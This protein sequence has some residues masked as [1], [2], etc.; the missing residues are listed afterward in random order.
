MIGSSFPAVRSATAR[1]VERAMLL[2]IAHGDYSPGERVPTCEQFARE[3]GVNKNTVSK[4][5][6]ALADLGYL[7]TVPGRGTFIVERPPV[8]DASHLEDVRGL[9]ALTV[10]EAKLAGLDRAQFHK[11]VDDTVAMYYSKTGLRVGFIEC[12]HMDA[13]TLSRDLQV[14]LAR[15]VDP[16]LL[17]SL[18]SDPQ[19]YSS[20]YDVLA[21]NLTHLIEVEGAIGKDARVAVVGLIIPPIATNLMEIARLTPGTRLAIVCDLEPTMENLRGLVSG[22]N[23]SL[24]VTTCLTS[25][26]E[27]DPTLIDSVDVIA[28]TVSAKG[29]I[30]SLKPHVPLIVISFKV[31]DVSVK[32]LASQISIRERPQ[33]SAYPA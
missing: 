2:R 16:L 3:L 8:A 12:N 10:Q 17:S 11:L 25:E 26:L 33:R 27:R 19:A 4:A 32:E 28:V 29:A 30:E 18:T 22:Y 15:P 24:V 20:A 7:R 9:L 31:D 21:V 23:P 13:A 1:D 6:R 14:A 5:F